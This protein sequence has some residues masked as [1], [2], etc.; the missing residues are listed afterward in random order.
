MA[1]KTVHSKKKTANDKTEEPKEEKRTTKAASKGASSME[2]LLANTG[3]D[4][5]GLKKGDTITGTITR[6]TAR[7]I[8]LDTGGKTEGIVMDR[9]LDTYKEMLSH[10]SPGDTVTA[11]VVVSEND[12]GQSVLSIRK[13]LLEKRWEAL[14]KAQKAGEPVEVTLREQVRGGILVDY[15]GIRGYVPQSQLDSALAK[16]LDKITGRKIQAKVIEVDESANRLVF[17]QRALTEEAALSRQKDLLDAVA[18]DSE[19]DTTITGVAPFG[20]FAKFRVEKDGETHDIEGLI[21]ISEIAWEKVDDPNQYLKTGDSIKVKVIGI[22]AATGKV[23][24]SVK[25]LLPDPW[26]H[27]LDQFEKDMQVKG[28]VTR[29]TPYGIFVEL[30]PGVEGLIHISKITPGTEP[31]AGEEITCIVEDLKPDQ[32]KISLSMALTEKPIGYR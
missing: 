20:A 11:Q 15:G 26:E 16:Q 5:K 27:V 21:H 12:R 4:L 17:S 29:T 24:L 22:D 19:V 32:R 31:K 23:T 8:A 13:S 3:Y 10:L 9:E 1:T 7:E 30:T 2:E 18:V 14:A 6:I 28:S 25:Q